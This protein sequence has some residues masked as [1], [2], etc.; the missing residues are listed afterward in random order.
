VK[1]RDRKGLYAKARKGL[2][3]NFTGI[4]DPYEAPTDAEIVIDTTNIYPEEAVEEILSYLKKA[5]YI[6]VE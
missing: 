6:G 2:L 4:S 3:P 1:K 5:G